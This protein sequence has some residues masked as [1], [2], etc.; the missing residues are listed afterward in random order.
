MKKILLL[1]GEMSGDL[2]AAN[3][4]N[5]LK[6]EKPDWQYYAMGGPKL[7]E[8]GAEIIADITSCSTIGFIEPIKYLPKIILAYFKLKKFVRENKVDLII[9][10]D[11]QGFNLLLL[12]YTKK[13]GIPSVYYIAPQEWIWGTIKG[14]KKVLSSVNLLLA[15]FKREAEFYKKISSNVEFIGHPIQD[16]IKQSISKQQFYEQN[17]ISKSKKILAIFPG[18]RSQE[19]ELVYPVLLDA[20][21]EIS[22]KF[23]DIQIVVS[24][25]SNK[26]E[27]KI[28]KKSQANKDIVFYDQNQYDLI[29]YSHLSFAKSGTIVLEHAVLGTPCLVGYRVS[30]F[31]FWIIKTFF[32]RII[33]KG[34]Y[35][36]PP[37]IVLNKMLFPE[38]LQDNFKVDSLIEKATELLEDEKLYN[39]FKQDIRNFKPHLGDPG[40]TQKAVKE[41]ISILQK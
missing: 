6:K 14:A 41:I 36:S 39:N 24:V 27:R 12:K 19:I 31:S 2:H 35:A 1:A 26:Y 20:A 17:N 9:P 33:E 38:F 23:S 5:T 7:A 16:I 18:T 32:P 15:I 40:A 21:T 34:K 29:R 30:D 22:N 13:L 10:I 3:L 25:S 8:A 4:L 11:Y 37:N 28:R